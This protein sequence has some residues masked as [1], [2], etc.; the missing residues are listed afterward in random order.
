[1]KLA[2]QK[3]GPTKYPQEEILDPRNT[4]EKKFWT[5]E[6][7]TIKI[8]GPTKYPQQKMLDLQNTYEKKFWSHEISTKK[9]FR[10]TKYPR[11]RISDHE[12][13][14]APREQRNLPQL[15]TSDFVYT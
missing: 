3:N 10:T 8:F 9:T 12:G 2:T 14:M 5:H 4:Y 1:M 15:V 11:E 6:I 7:L 13:T